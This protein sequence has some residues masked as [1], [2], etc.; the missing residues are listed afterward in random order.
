MYKNTLET[1]IQNESVEMI[2]S[3]V[4][5]KFINVTGF[6][7]PLQY[8]LLLYLILY[9]YENIDLCVDLIKMVLRNGADINQVVQD[10]DDDYSTALSATIGC[11]IGS[12]MKTEEVSNEVSNEVRKADLLTIISILMVNGANANI[13]FPDGNSVKTSLITVQ[14]E[15]IIDSTD[16]NT[17]LMRLL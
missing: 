5:Q 8:S 17:L 9:R 11:Y 2:E 10:T 4:K 15:N 3:L 16:L 6:Y 13:V 12:C 1:V 7:G 14:N